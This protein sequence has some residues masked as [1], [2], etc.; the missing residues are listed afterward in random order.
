ML[1]N[2]TQYILV[3]I[4]GSQTQPITQPSSK[5]QAI[6]KQK[7][8]KNRGDWKGYKIQLRTPEGYKNVKILTKKLPK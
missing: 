1:N 7:E 6:Y 3:A 5:Q 2:S 8:I 4:K